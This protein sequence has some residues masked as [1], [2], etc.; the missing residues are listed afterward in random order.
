MKETDD[1]YEIFQCPQVQTTKKDPVKSFSTLWASAKNLISL[2]KHENVESIVKTTDVFV[3]SL[4]TLAT[5]FIDYDGDEFCQGMI[6]GKEGSF[7]L[8]QIAS[9]L[10]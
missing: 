8:V 7:M 9:A 5:V 10:A 3:K 6:F 2:I 4:G 1:A